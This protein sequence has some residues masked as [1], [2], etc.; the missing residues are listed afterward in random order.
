MKTPLRFQITEYDCGTVSLMNAI[1]YIFEREEIPAILLKKIYKYTLDCEDIYGN[2][3]QGG[4]S[5]SS[6]DRLCKWT[7]AFTKKSDFPFCC[8][9]LEGEKITLDKM[10]FTLQNKGCILMRT[11]LTEEHYVLITKIKINKVY[12][13]DPYYLPKEYYIN[14]KNIKIIYNKPFSHNR[15]I[16]LKRL[17]EEN[18]KDLSLGNKKNRECVLI[19]RK[20]L[21]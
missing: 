17:F 9:H 10:L 1:C 11:H 18:N 5:K 14:D 21:S 20:K 12:I 13:F 3:G 19:S 2:E 7:A 15:I 6:I 4:T 16:S 8:Q